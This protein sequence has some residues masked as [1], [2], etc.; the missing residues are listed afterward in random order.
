MWMHDVSYVTGK[1]Q[2]PDP[3][4]HQAEVDFE[5]VWKACDEVLSQVK[6]CLHM[7]DFMHV[8]ADRNTLP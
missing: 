3:C 8:S 1:M 5:A 6:V 2:R 7:L 4:H